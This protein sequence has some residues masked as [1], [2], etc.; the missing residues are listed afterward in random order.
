MFICTIQVWLSYM[1]TPL[2][3]LYSYML[4]PLNRSLTLSGVS[5]LPTHHSGIISVPAIITHCAPHIVHADFHSA[6]IWNVT[7]NQLNRTISASCWERKCWKV[8]NVTYTLAI[9][10]IVLH[11]LLASFLVNGIIYCI[12]ISTVLARSWKNIDARTCSTF[13]GHPEGK[14]QIR[15]RYTGIST[16]CF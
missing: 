14:A 2:F 11:M 4:H 10:C 7:P 6:L 1:Y 12:L 9:K 16:L 13:D 3:L 8:N 5:K 15:E